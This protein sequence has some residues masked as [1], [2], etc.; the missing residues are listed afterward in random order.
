MSN[1]NPFYRLHKPSGQA[2]VTFDGQDI[3]LGRYRSSESRAEYDRLLAEWLANGR[4]LPAAEGGNPNLAVSELILAY[5]EFADGYYRKGGEPTAEVDSIKVTMRPLK[6]LYGPTPAREFGPLRLKAVREAF[7]ESGLCRNEVNKRTGRV[8]RMFK[9]AVE[10]ELVPSS[11]HHGLRAVCGLRRG[12]SG[13]RESKKVKPIHGSIV[14]AT[15]PHVPRQ[16][17]AMIEL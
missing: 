1:R 8:V 14:D 7:V 2:V 16:V 9:R 13:V 6:K 4:R 11:V 15:L 10:T 12:R 3:Y 5:I 17:A